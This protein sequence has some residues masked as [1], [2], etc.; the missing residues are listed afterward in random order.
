MPIERLDCGKDLSVAIRGHRFGGGGTAISGGRSGG[1]QS[2]SRTS[3]LLM[4]VIVRV[5]PGRAIHGASASDPCSPRHVSL[6]P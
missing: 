6:L 5:S 1:S 3:A 2:G 4:I